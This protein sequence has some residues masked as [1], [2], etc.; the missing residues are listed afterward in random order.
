MNPFLLM[1]VVY[2]ALAVLTAVDA[3]LTSFSVLGMFSGLRWLRIHFITLGGVT[4]ALFGVLP[5]LMAIHA[6]RSRP[7]IRWDIWLSFN[8]GLLILLVGIPL[9]NHAL[10][11]AGGAF[12]F[13]AAALLIRQLFEMRPAGS[14]KLASPSLKFYIVGVAY[15]LVGIVIGTGLWLGWSGPLGIAVPIEVHIHANNWGFMSMVFAGLLVD[16][17]PRVT[18]RSLAWPASTTPI[19][20]LMTLGALGL[21][22]GPWTQLNL[23]SVPGL[24]MHLTATIWLLL[25]V[26]R[27]LRG[28]RQA[29]TPG[30]WHLVT[31]YAWI[32]APVLVAPLIIGGV[33]G[34]PGIGIEQNAPQALVYGWML[35]FGYAML[36]YLFTRVLL[37]E[38][39]PELGG[40]WFSLVT[41]H[42]GGA[43]LWASIFITAYQSQLHGLAYALWALSAVP[44]VL[45]LGRIVRS[46]LAR[47]ERALPEVPTG[48]E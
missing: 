39:I 25:N 8:A 40:G 7:A 33:P 43:F 48:A 9:V 17:Y 32:L 42:L 15:L 24:L 37:P 6:K 34:F 23:L 27:P 26:V 10:I 2:L 16:I 22:L 5:L 21:V 30:V 3:S 18:G 13:G 31:S 45:Q 41:V 44:I 46:G 29:W 14:E 11:L 12:I 47:P 4:E 28:D 20:W 19:F 38:K 35:Q 36:P 1:A